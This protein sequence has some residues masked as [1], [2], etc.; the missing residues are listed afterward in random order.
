M[1]VS[2]RQTSK[3][4]GF[5]PGMRTYLECI[6][7]FVR[8]A[9]D[10]VRRVT[11]DEAVHE[12]VLREVLGTS[13][14]MDLGDS[15][16]AMAQR[17]H[18]IIRKITGQEDPY[19]GA[20]DADN[21]SALEMYPHLKQRVEDSARPL[22]TA[23]RLAIAGNIIDLGVK[24]HLGEPD[25]DKAV[26]DAFTLP[27]PP[28]SV[29]SFD[30]A[31]QQAG[32]II[33]LADNAGEIVFDRLLV[34]QIPAEKV[35]FVVR[36]GPIINDATMVDAEAAGL[37]DLVEVVDN[38]SDAPGTI[39]DQCSEEFRRRF[40]EADMVIAKGQGNY[41]TLSDVD[42]DIFF[43]F[44]VKCPVIGRGIGREVGSMVLHRREPMLPADR[45][46]AD[47]HARI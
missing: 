42:K 1:N 38:G 11:D 43:L 31:V 37:T 19:R 46:E 29:E 21:R 18:R 28:G 5:K 41:E 20:K 39:L 47:Y 16:P 24:T 33:Y 12:K 35:T 23:I 3:N 13:A 32:R 14:R 36:G 27:L 34:E 26:R 45:K 2:P 10:A 15:P 6:P 7:C 22:E 40:D 44:K 9:L 17:L 30:I 8:Q 4:I 25:V